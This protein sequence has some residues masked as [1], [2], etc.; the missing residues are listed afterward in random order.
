LP[1]ERPN[2][3]G[4]MAPGPP[5]LGPAAPSHSQNI[6]AHP[7]WGKLTKDKRR[8]LETCCGKD[9]LRSGFVIPAWQGLFQMKRPQP[10]LRPFRNYFAD[11]PAYFLRRSRAS[12]SPPPITA[13][14]AV[15]GSGTVVTVTSVMA[16]KPEVNTFGRPTVFTKVTAPVPRFTV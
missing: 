6:E 3:L 16:S 4:G 5:A 7:S 2:G 13:K 10:K 14:A 9:R 12:I 15:P 1:L 11:V 8:M